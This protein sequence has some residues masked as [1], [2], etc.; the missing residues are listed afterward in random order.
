MKRKKINRSLLFLS[1][2]GI[3]VTIIAMSVVYA[4]LSSKL[5]IDGSAEISN[6]SFDL[7]VEKWLVSDIYGDDYANVCKT[8]NYICYDNVILRGNGLVVNEPKVSGTSIK[9]FKLSVE[10]PDDMSALSYKI[11]NYGTIPVKL[12]NIVINDYQVTSA[13]NLESDVSW[14]NENVAVA[15]ML[16]DINMSTDKNIND[17]LCPGDSWSVVFGVQISSSSTTLPSGSVEVSNMGVTYEFLQTDQYLCE[18]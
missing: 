1:L 3:F 10:K 15:H 18:R 13:N 11:T 6:S 4:A 8:N 14:F 7:K 9:D 12:S 16:E 5:L 2:C 17:I